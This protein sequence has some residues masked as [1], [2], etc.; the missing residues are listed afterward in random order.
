MA[1]LGRVL[2]L[3]ES[4]CVSQVVAVAKEIAPVALHC[5][6]NA[7]TVNLKRDEIRCGSSDRSRACRTRSLKVDAD[8]TNVAMGPDSAAAAA[9]TRR[10]DSSI[11]AGRSAGLP[12]ER[13]IGLC[14]YATR[15]QKDSEQKHCVV[16][17]ASVA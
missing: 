17:R 13:H 4:I 1:Q 6:I 11:N 3:A 16:C 12:C 5:C 9:G 10:H 14:M 15:E 2:A 8:G 7:L